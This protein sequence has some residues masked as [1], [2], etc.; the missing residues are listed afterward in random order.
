M[1]THDGDVLK[2]VHRLQKSLTSLSQG[3]AVLDTV[4]YDDM[5]QEHKIYVIITP[6]DGLYK[7]ARVKFEVGD[8]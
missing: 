6:H 2:E 5:N 1:A 7:G 3:Q 8:T 4:E